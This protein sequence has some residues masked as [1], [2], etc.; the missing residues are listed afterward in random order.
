MP[1]GFQGSVVVDA[2]GL[3]VGV[4]NNVNYDVPFDGSAAYNM[5]VAATT[6]LSFSL[7][8]EREEE[9]GEADGR[10][11]VSLP[12]PFSVPVLLEITNERP[13]GANVSFTDPGNTDVVAGFTDA[14]GLLV[15]DVFL[16]AAPPAT[17]D[18][19]VY[20]DVNSNGILDL[21]VDILM[22]TGTF[23]IS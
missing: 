14:S 18:V 1:G 17:F 8:E 12:V 23:A 2:A 16:L 21:G 4:S 3:V 15:Q 22:A 19:N 5:P 10:L 6:L 13:P 20:Y 7:L 11:F 9:D